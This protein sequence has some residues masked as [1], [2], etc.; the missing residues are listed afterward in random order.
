M[1]SYSLINILIILSQN[2]INGSNIKWSKIS[3]TKIRKAIALAKRYLKKLNEE[4]N[5]HE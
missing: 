2:A 1:E 4:K 3:Q 5:D